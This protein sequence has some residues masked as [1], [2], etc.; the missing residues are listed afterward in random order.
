MTEWEDDRLPPG[1]EAPISG[2]GKRPKAKALGYPASPSE[3]EDWAGEGGAGEGGWGGLGCGVGF[4][5]WS[6]C[7]MR[8][9]GP[10]KMLCWGATAKLRLP[11]MRFPAAYLICASSRRS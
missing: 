2:L 4:G 7:A 6:P 10:A 5:G 3:F 1:A 11:V 8:M 9:N